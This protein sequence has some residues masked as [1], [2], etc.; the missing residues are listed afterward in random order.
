[1]LCASS[2]TTHQVVAPLA[3]SSHY[4][5]L[6]VVGVLVLVDKYVCEKITVCG[7][8]VGVVAQEHVGVEKEVVEVHCAGY[9]AAVAVGLVYFDCAFAA[10]GAVVCHKFLVGGVVF[11]RTEHV[12]GPRNVGQHLA[13]AVDFVVELHLAYYCLDER[14]GVG[15]VVDGKVRVEAYS[16]GM[17]AEY[18]RKDRV[19]RTHP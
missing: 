13:G 12:F 18:A 2:P 14:L 3:K 8:Y 5:V 6:G 1:M 15:C 7:E 10:C 17:A 19:E 4:L 9:T 16:V 11:G